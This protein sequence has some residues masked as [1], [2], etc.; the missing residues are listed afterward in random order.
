M[1]SGL[2]LDE[3]E[4][5]IDIRLADVI[6]QP[7]AGFPVNLHQ[8]FVGEA[9]DRGL[10]LQDLN[11]LIKRVMFHFVGGSIGIIM[12]FHQAF[13]GGEVRDHAVDEKSQNRGSFGGCAAML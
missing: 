2:A 3:E 6:E 9:V 1:S 10:R 12:A 7:G 8:Q 13:F 5:E 11:P 4:A